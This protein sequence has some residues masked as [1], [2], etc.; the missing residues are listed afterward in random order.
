[1]PLAVPENTDPSRPTAA[2]SNAEDE[3]ARAHDR[4]GHSA[5]RTVM[6]SEARKA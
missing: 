4:S 5:D 3:P 2:M 6:T 1:M